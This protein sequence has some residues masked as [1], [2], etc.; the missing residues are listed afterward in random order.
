MTVQAIA[1][2][3]LD[4]LVRIFNHLLIDQALQND[5]VVHLHIL[6]LDAVTN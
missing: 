3:P 1:L 2:E 4:Q 6:K 5:T